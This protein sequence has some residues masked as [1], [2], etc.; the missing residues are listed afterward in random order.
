MV[1]IA[2]QSSK[3]VRNVLG[4]RE[5]V[6]EPEWIRRCDLFPQV[7]V[8]LHVSPSL[9]VHRTERGTDHA[10][11]ALDRK[12]RVAE[13]VDGWPAPVAVWLVGQHRGW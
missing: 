12:E 7:E 3:R 4:L 10:H 9:T 8:F 13:F 5:Y 2:N 6:L 11:L 1:G